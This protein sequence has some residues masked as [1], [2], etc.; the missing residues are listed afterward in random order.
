MKNGIQ[1]VMKNRAVAKLFLRLIL[2]KQ[3]KIE[4]KFV[5]NMIFENREILINLMIIEN[6]LKSKQILIHLTT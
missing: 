4:K 1:K 3:W 6:L 5:R 2:R